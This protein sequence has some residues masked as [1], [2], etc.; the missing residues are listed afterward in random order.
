M[1]NS[2]EIGFTENAIKKQ[3]IEETAPNDTSIEKK[4]TKAERNV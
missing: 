4:P 2:K 3:A 1:L